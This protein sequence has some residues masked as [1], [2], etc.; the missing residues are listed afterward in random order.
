M[1]RAGALPVVL[2]WQ[3][4]DEEGHAPPPRRIKKETKHDGEGADPPH[5]E[6][7][8]TRRGGAYPLLVASKRTW[9]NDG[10][11]C[12]PS[13]SWNSNNVVPVRVVSFFFKKR[14]IWRAHLV[15]PAPQPRP[16]TSST[17]STISSSSFYSLILVV[18]WLW[19]HGC[20]VVGR[21]GGGWRRRNEKKVEVQLTCDGA[22]TWL[23]HVWNGT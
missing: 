3:Q 10:E 12:Q 13:L 4:R 5:R 14:E 1:G 18:S 22:V 7:A 2:K 19:R 15:H 21:V 11:G 23:K 17:F 20:G 16:S 6:M 9:E 8:T